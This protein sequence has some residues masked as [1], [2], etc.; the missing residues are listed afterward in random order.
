MTWFLTY[1]HNQNTGENKCFILNKFVW[2][3][4]IGLVGKYNAFIN[5]YQVSIQT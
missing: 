3:I 2:Q 5:Y 4:Y 1:G